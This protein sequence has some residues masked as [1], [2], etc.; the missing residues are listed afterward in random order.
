MTLAT[1]S[2]CGIVTCPAG[3]SASGLHCGIKPSG[4]TD[5]AL[6]CCEQEANVAAVFTQNLVLAAPIDISAQHLQRSNGRVRALLINSGIANAATGPEGT[7][8]AQQTVDALAAAL[9]C[10]DDRILINS[11]GVIGEPLPA[12]TIVQAIPHLVTMILWVNA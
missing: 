12:N 5:L 6:V 1:P 7:R 4:D 10:E 11:T 8:S 3:F 2:A 9:E